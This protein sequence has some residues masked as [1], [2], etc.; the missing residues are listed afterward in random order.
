MKIG[1]NLQQRVTGAENTGGTQRLK[2]S[3]SMSCN[4][5]CSTSTSKV[6]KTS[7]SEGNQITPGNRIFGK[8][9]ITLIWKDWN[10]VFIFD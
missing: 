3:S 5:S 2:S 1:I 7:A 10:F 4:N 6:F 9:Y 8:L